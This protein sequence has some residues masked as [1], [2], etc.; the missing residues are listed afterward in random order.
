MA[1]KALLI[2]GFG[3]LI[4]FGIAGWVQGENE[5]TVLEGGDRSAEPQP[6]IAETIMPTRNL[7]GT[8]GAANESSLNLQQISGP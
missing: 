8:R 3:A 2:I 7:E 4:G 6:K 5:P 1:R